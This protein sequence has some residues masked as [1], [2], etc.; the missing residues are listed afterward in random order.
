[1]SA[2]KLTFP[3]PLPKNQ[4]DLICMLLAG[5]LKDLFK[6]KLIC[7]E[8]ALGDLLKDVAGVPGLTDLAGALTGM[9]SA[10]SGFKDASGYN[11]ILNGVNSALG[12]IENVFSLGGLCPSPVHAPQIPDLLPQLNANLF[13]Q[14][15]N[16]LSALGQLSNPSMCLGGGPGGFGV[17]WNSMPGDLRNLKAAIGAFKQDPGGLQT[18][19]NAFTSNIKSQVSRMNSE[20]KRLE[21]NLADPL[22]LN[23]KLNTSQNLQRVKSIS[24]G[25]AVKDANGILHNSAVKSM[26]SADIESTIDNGDGTS[27]KYITKPKLDYCGDV[28]GYEKVAVSGDSAYIGWDPNNS[29]VNTD[30]P[31]VN[32]VAG[33]SSFTYYFAEENGL[34]KVYNSDSKVVT[35]LT[36][37]RGYAYRLGFELTTKKIQFYS[38][39]TYTTVWTKGLTY[40][41]NPEYGAFMEIITPDA[42]TVFT[43]GE[44]DWAVLIE[45]PT[46]PN[47]IYWKTIDGTSSGS[48]TID[49][50]TVI[51]EADRTYDI[52]MAARKATLQLIHETHNIPDT[53]NIIQYETFNG[54]EVVTQISSNPVVRKT[55]STSSNT[56]N[57]ETKIYD[58]NGAVTSTATSSGVVCVTEYNSNDEYNKTIK[59]VTKYDSTKYL[60]TK[61][62]VNTQNGLAFSGIDFYI[63]TD[64]T[65]ASSTHCLLIKF[66]G[67]VILLNSSKLP[68]TS[69]YSYKLTYL[70]KDENNDFIPMMAPISNAEELK[71]ELYKDG[72]RQYIRWNLTSNTLAN[73]P[74]NEIVFQVDIEIDP[75][76]LKRDFIDCNPIEYR[77][78]F[79]FKA[80]DNTAVSSE[81]TSTTHI[82]V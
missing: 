81:L 67:P 45:N 8:L 22:G 61:R 54:T 63:S 62:Y 21:Q 50:I 41:A 29:T 71:F 57:S 74:K 18:T 58:A 66:D 3:T 47:T 78:Y 51:P 59:T 75:A 79:R 7:A 64:E 72:S 19:I 80:N 53:D 73:L 33:H 77:T 34:V 20:V 26:V 44:L 10:I 12:Q 55:V 49:G 35:A 70:Q 43:T 76:H 65:E 11:A 30:N 2:L 27:V 52:S 28:V 46:T 60:I 15:N 37:S 4:K 5:R 31:T 39:S 1:M 17:N 32:P 56:Y 23:D 25:Y 38:D 9:S 13:G 36:L 42:N 48:F 69:N 82:T 40:S 24:D 68:Y 16:I 6:G 14:A